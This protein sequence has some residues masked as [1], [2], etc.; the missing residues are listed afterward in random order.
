MNTRQRY[1]DLF[2]DIAWRYAEMSHCTE[3][4]QGSVIVRDRNI[5]SAGFSGQPKGMPNRCELEDG[6]LNPIVIDPTTNSIVRL[7]MTNESSDGATLYTT[8]YPDMAACKLI[9]QCGIVRVV[10]DTINPY[11]DLE[12]L[13]EQG[14]FV[15]KYTKLETGE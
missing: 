6:S 9:I 3:Y 15:D 1:D 8:H 14:L 12:F 13:T 7:A 2:I 11:Y 5:I 10:F 4:K